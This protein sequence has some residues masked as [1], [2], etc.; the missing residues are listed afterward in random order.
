M[1]WLFNCRTVLYYKCGGRLREKISQ[2]IEEKTVDEEVVIQL[3]TVGVKVTNY[4]RRDLLPLSK[5]GEQ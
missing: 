2:S 3:R 4:E 5:R 1:F